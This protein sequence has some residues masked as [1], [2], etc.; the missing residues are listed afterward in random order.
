VSG[1]GDPPGA[2]QEP[3]GASQDP[4]GASTD[5]PLIDRERHR[6]Q[7]AERRQEFTLH[8]DRAKIVSRA[9]V[10]IIQD[11]R[12]EAHCASFTFASDEHAPVGEGTAP[13]PLQYFVAAVGL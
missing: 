6:K 8:P 12:K 2:S 11:Y 1:D 7:H 4:P 5:R 10:R 13:S 9:K 3:P